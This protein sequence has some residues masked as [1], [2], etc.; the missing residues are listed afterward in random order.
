MA[1][2]RSINNGNRPQP[3]I[4]SHKEKVQRKAGLIVSVFHQLNPLGEVNEPY[5]SHTTLLAHSP[6]CH[7][8]SGDTTKGIM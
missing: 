3:I 1:E 2:I 6:H 7:F 5:F 4:F 8:L